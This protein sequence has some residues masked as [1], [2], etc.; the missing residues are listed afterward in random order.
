VAIRRHERRSAAVLFADISG[1]TGLV[2]M[3]DPEVVYQTVRPLM[4]ELVLLVE[5]YGG[6]VQQVLGDGFMAVF[7]LRATLGD[8]AER[9]VRAA[10]ALVS[11]PT[12]PDQPPVHA[13]VEYGSVLVTPSWEPARFGV[14]GRPVTIARRLCEV[15]G[16]GQV[17]VGPGAYASARHSVDT[18]TPARLTLKGIG[19]VPAYRL[20]DGER[21]V[22]APVA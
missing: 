22:L 6:E 5:R 9:A 16:P 18:A 12:D 10:R 19:V 1:F 11:V 15:A 7:G 21:R 2:E 3:F 17:H 4:D 20:R 8:E 14:W 13:G